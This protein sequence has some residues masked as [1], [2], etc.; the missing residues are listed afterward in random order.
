[1]GGEFVSSSFVRFSIRSFIRNDSLSGDIKQSKRCQPMCRN[2]SSE[3]TSTNVCA[4]ESDKN[5]FTLPNRSFPNRCFRFSRKIVFKSWMALHSIPS[6]T[7]ILLCSVVEKSK[8]VIRS[9][10]DLR[11]YNS[12]ILVLCFNK[13]R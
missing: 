12:Q 13:M 6:L 8:D 1:M 5:H 10:S 7:I 9:F 3:V 2:L 11:Q 4:Q